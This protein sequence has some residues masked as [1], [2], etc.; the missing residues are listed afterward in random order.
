MI[1]KRVNIIYFESFKRNI[2]RTEAK[3]ENNNKIFIEQY[4][5]HLP[6]LE[7]EMLE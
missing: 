6:H 7:L 4:F 1:H 2:I 3:K 5:H